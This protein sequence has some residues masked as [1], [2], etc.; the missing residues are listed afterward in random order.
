MVTREADNRDDNR[1]DGRHCAYSF[2]PFSH[3]LVA[4]RVAAGAADTR[5]AGEEVG[6][7]RGDITYGGMTFRADVFEFHAHGSSLHL[8][9]VRLTCVLC[10]L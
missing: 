5:R 8:L 6:L 4:Q 9:R 2:L 3:A 1:Y 7:H 10:S